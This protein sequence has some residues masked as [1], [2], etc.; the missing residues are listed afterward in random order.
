MVASLFALTDAGAVVD[1]L[2]QDAGQEAVGDYLGADA[3]GRTR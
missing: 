1:Y 3:H 2:G